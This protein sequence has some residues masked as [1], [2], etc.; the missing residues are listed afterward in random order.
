MDPSKNMRRNNP[1]R[2]NAQFNAKEAFANAL[3]QAMSDPAKFREFKNILS[4]FHDRLINEGGSKDL[5]V[6]TVR[7]A[8]TEATKQ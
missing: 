2:A 4:M 7:K 6:K 1:E 5:N 8:L 3:E